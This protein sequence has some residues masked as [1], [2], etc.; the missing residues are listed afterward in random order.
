MRKIYRDEERFSCARW[1][2]EGTAK[3][4]EEDDDT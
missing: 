2:E 1:E 3:E 4:A